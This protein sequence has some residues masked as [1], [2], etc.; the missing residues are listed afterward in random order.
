[1]A[2]EA[3]TGIFLAIPVAFDMPLP[4]PGIAWEPVRSALALLV[5][6]ALPLLVYRSLRA[7]GDAGEKDLP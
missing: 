6:L 2:G 3:L 7:E 4:L 5:L 1:V